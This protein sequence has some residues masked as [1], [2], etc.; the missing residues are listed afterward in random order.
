MKIISANNCPIRLELIKQA[1][2]QANIKWH[3]GDAQLFALEFDASARIAV[4][5]TEA[6]TELFRN[7]PKTSY[8]LCGFPIQLDE[9]IAPGFIELCLKGETIVRVESLAI[10]IGF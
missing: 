8:T 6:E 3:M 2:V 4:D 9:S 1:L 7:I 10:P 5:Q